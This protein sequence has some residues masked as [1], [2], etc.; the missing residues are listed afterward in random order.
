MNEP[1]GPEKLLRLSGQLLPFKAMRFVPEHIG[2]LRTLIVAPGAVPEKK[3]TSDRPHVQHLFPHG[4]K[5]SDGQLS[6]TNGSTY[7]FW[8]REGH[9]QSDPQKSLYI[10][11][12]KFKGTDGHIRVR[13]G[14]YAL[15]ELTQ[16]GG[17]QILPHERTFPKRIQ[18]QVDIYQWRQAQILPLFLLYSDPKGEVQSRLAGFQ[19]QKPTM[20][21]TD[22]LDQQ[23]DLWQVTDA[24]AIA[25]FQA[26]FQA[27]EL[28]V[29]DG[30]HRYA[31]AVKYWKDRQ[32][33]NAYVI[34]YL[35]PAESDGLMMGTF[36]RGIRGLKGPLSEAL[37]GLESQ[38]TIESLPFET[39]FKAQEDLATHKANMPPGESR[40]TYILLDNKQVYYRLT[41]KHP[42]P[43]DAP[44]VEKLDISHFHHILLPRMKGWDVCCFE[45]NPKNL[46]DKL[47]RRQIDLV[48]LLAAPTPS[49]VWDVARHGVPM[50][51]KAT[52]FHPK[53][54]A[55][56]VH[57]PLDE[58]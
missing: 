57:F 54:P 50:P 53:V 21:F 34:A 12:L 10:H 5:K 44:I 13:T 17:L 43:E 38:F 19:A 35:T 28:L 31:A 37:A 7:H 41:A 8:R 2:D 51:A 18:R 24:D 15:L 36:H 14:V 52:N 6:G 3:P 55:G 30:H 58:D 39:A 33:Q 29:A 42:I 26:F 40:P 16:A 4:D 1:F 11:R 20:S 47:Q 46:M 22:H 9:I 27:G 23:N 48:C 45:Q 56:L 32:S 25:Q 49:T